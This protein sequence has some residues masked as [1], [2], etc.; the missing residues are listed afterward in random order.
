MCVFSRR[1]NRV[2]EPIMRYFLHHIEYIKQYLLLQTVTDIQEN[3]PLYTKT[4]IN[5]VCRA[6]KSQYKKY[7][8]MSLFSKIKMFS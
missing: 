6:Y 8:N 5:T 2:K 3:I 1:T 4:V 7:V